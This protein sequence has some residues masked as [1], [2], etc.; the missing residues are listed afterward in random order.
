MDFKVN[1]AP[2]NSVHF[3][4]IIRLH[5]FFDPS[6]KRSPTSLRYYHLR[7]DISICS[8]SKRIH[9]DLTTIV[10]FDI[11]LLSLYSRGHR[12]NNNSSISNYVLNGYFLKVYCLISLL[13]PCVDNELSTLDINLQRNRTSLLS[14]Q[15]SVIPNYDISSFLE[16]F[17]QLN[18]FLDTHPEFGS[19]L[20]S[21]EMQE[22]LSQLVQN[23]SRLADI[24]RRHDQELRNIESLP[25]GFSALERL[26]SEIQE[27]LQDVFDGI[28]PNLYLDQDRSDMLPTQNA[29]NRRPLYNPWNSA[30]H[31]RSGFSNH[32]RLRPLNQFNI[33]DHIRLPRNSLP[34]NHNPHISS[35]NSHI[36]QQETIQP[37]SNFTPDSIYNRDRGTSDRFTS[38][39][40]ILFNMG[41]RD[42]NRNFEALLATNGDIELAIHLLLSK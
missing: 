27:P 25:G 13:K 34:D 20:S 40:Q 9:F 4:L 33:D 37:Y 1:F 29:V 32:H 42:N 39:L 3:P 36:S 15:H 7:N 14:S 10:G 26:Y 8:F 11:K 16:Y 17:P 41:F 19:A 24:M 30:S 21:T 31:N 6:V 23:P 38:Q 28:L 35:N 18:D 22:I 2:P 5:L 12:M